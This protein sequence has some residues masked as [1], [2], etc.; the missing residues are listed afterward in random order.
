MDA[1]FR[2][3]GAP[4]TFR[5][6]EF[7]FDSESRLLLCGGTERH[8]SPKAQQLLLAL[9]VAKPRALSR[10]EL[11]DALWPSTFVCETNLAGVVNEVR[12]ALDDDARAAQYIRTVHG[13]GYAFGG[14][15][16]LPAALAASAML[17]CGGRHHPLYEG[18][19]C[20]GRAVDAGVVLTETMVSRRH[21]LITVHG[22]VFTIRDLDSKNGTYVEG[23]RV[24]STPVTVSPRSRITLGTLTVSIVPRKTTSTQSLHLNAPELQ[25][26]VAEALA[27]PVRRS[28][29]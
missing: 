11:Y 19:N 10:E 9:L 7:T 27:R 5:F 17:S 15:A 14:D 12:R 8:L 3:A 28:S 24:G 20:V 6:G 26:R 21:A 29:P 13:F 25:R 2:P 4:A 1:T 23:K 16:S 18:D 22:G